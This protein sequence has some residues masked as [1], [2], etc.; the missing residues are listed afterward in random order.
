MAH[1][2][3]L[4]LGENSVKRMTRFCIDYDKPE[5]TYAGK[6]FDAFTPCNVLPQ[7]YHQKDCWKLYVAGL[8]F[9][10][11]QCDIEGKQ[12]MRVSQVLL[13]NDTWVE[14][15]GD[16]GYLKPQATLEGSYPS[17]L[18]HL[19]ESCPKDT[20]VSAFDCHF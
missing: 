6:M 5:A 13:P 20:L 19:L 16:E 7:S 10:V 9:T 14:V 18:I 11:F 15:T 2:I 8:E 12:G 4:V 1:S 3:I 17:N